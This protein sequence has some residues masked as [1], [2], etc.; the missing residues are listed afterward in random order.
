MSTPFVHDPVPGSDVVIAQAHSP[1][2]CAILL[3]G[4][5]LAAA[6]TAGA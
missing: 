3:L 6:G 1:Q 5:A 4:P 2:V